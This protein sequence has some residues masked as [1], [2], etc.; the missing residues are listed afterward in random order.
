MFCSVHFFPLRS[1]LLANGDIL[2]SGFKSRYFCSRNISVSL[3]L[4]HVSKICTLNLSSPYLLYALSKWILLCLP[5][6]SLLL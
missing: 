1:G 6:L 3:T 4:E 2:Y 5:V